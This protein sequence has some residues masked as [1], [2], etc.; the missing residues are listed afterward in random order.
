[1]VL[2]SHQTRV[3]VVSASP[4]TRYVISG[5]LSSEPDLFVV[6]TARTPDEVAYK[7]SLLQPDLMVID[8]ES[9]GDLIDL[10]QTLLKTKLP[11]LALCAHTPDGAELAF[12]AL[13]AGATDVVARTE[14]G[15][16]VMDYQSDLLRKVR[17]LANL[18][19]RSEGRVWNGLKQCQKTTPR[20]FYP[21]DHLVVVSV[22]TGGLGPLV[23][24]LNALPGDLR[25]AVLILTHL[26][27]FYL[28]ACVRRVNPITSLHVREVRDGLPIKSGVIYFAPYDF[29]MTVGSGGRLTLERDLRHR[30]G[31]LSVDATLKSLAMRY[32]PA[33]I[34]VILSGIGQDG[35][36]GAQ[37]VRAAGGTVIVQEV[38]S[39]LAGETPAAVIQRGA[40]TA[41]LAVEN[42]AD[43]IARRVDDRLRG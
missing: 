18:A 13:E 10:H 23:Q 27:S 15:F 22:S 40:A 35:A 12:A 43:D 2:G 41:V 26:P 24:L 38:S 19:P 31:R 39:C 21:N 5:E 4:Y 14:S 6:G 16:G 8:L 9:Q 1:M 29:Q 37:D 36:L 7:Q 42:I 33:V 25:A 17:G 34:A 20:R 28:S 3:L 30:E 11:V 32:G